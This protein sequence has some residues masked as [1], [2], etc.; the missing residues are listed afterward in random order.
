MPTLPTYKFSAITWIKKVNQYLNTL[1]LFA[2]ASNHFIDNCRLYTILKKN[3]INNLSLYYSDLH[4][5]GCNAIVFNIIYFFAIQEIFSCTVQNFSIQSDFYKKKQKSEHKF[6]SKDQNKQFLFVM[7][8]FINRRNLHPITFSVSN[9]LL[10]RK[11]NYV[12]QIQVLTYIKPI[13]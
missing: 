13:C 9:I 4:S 2:L 11:G 12:L 5:S 10:I 3:T 1:R 7:T 6:D 8:P